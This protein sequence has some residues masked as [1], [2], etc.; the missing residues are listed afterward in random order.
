MHGVSEISGQE[1][2]VRGWRQGGD[3]GEIK[4]TGTAPPPRK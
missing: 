2:M 1:P 4:E 3:G